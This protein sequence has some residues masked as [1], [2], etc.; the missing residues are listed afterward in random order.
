MSYDTRAAHR[1]REARIEAVEENDVADPLVTADAI[2]DVASGTPVLGD[3]IVFWH[4]GVPKRC[5]LTALQTLI[6]V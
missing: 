6:N 4:G 3:Y 2:D 1:A 5:T